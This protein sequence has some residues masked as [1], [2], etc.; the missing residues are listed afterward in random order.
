M[1]EVKRVLGHRSG[2]SLKDLVYYLF[3][4]EVGAKKLNDMI[5]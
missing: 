5:Q 1:R 3:E 2:S 4:E